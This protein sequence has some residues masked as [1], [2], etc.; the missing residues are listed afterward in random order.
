MKE[1][2]STLLLS[3]EPIRGLSEYGL[4]WAL[5]APIQQASPKGD[6]HPV[7]IFPGLGAADGSTHYIR[8]FIDDL[9]YESFPWGMGRNLGPR[10]GIDEM[11]HRLKRLVHDIAKDT[12]KQ[13]SLIGWSLGGI[14][15]REAA[16]L[17]PEDVRQVITLGTPFKEL[18]GKGS[19]HAEKFYELLSNDKSHKDEKIIRQI[20]IPP[21]VPFT[22]IYSKTDGVVNWKSSIEKKDHWVENIEIPLASHLGLGHNP[23]VMYVIADRLSHTKEMWKPF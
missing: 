21:P 12:G 5:H 10:L 2:P 13:V 4:A 1:A 17:C 20:E 22:S 23:I 7:L 18:S 14:Y 11:A 6:G 16:K 9:G 15:A 19:T 3:L 8:N